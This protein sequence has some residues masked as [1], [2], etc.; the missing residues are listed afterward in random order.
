MLGSRLREAR[1]NKGLTQ[2]E[3]A[4]LLGK[5]PSVITNWENGTN[6]PDADLIGD[7]CSILS[8]TPNWLLGWKSQDSEIE[9]IAAHN[10]G[11]PLSEEE[12]ERVRE[13]ARFIKSQRKDE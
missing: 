1:K 8:I 10:D 4:K 11:P 12:Q 7:I 9:T 3:L 13:F 5:T 6:R 2:A